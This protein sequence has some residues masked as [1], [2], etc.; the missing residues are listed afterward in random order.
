MSDKFDLILAHA[1]YLA[2]Q[3]QVIC[4]GDPDKMSESQI[5]DAV[6]RRKDEMIEEELRSLLTGGRR[7]DGSIVFTLRSVK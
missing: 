3:R 4:W 1:R 5:E 6:K 7:R 2:S